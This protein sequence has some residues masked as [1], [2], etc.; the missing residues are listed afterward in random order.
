MT[1]T[2]RATL[3]ATLASLALACDRPKDLP[4][5]GLSRTTLSFEAPGGSGEPAPQTVYVRNTGRGSLAAPSATITYASGAGWLAA[6]VSGGGA[7]YTVTVQPT[8]AG[9]APGLYGATLTL[10]CV[11]AS[12]SPA[13]VD[14]IL[15]VPDPRFILS[16]D[17]LDL[18]APRGGGDP[19][20]ATF[21]VVNGGR[22]TLPVPEVA[23]SYVG[24][25]GW[26]STEVSGTPDAYTV[27]VFA[28]AS[29]FDSGAYRATLAISAP[30]AEGPPRTLL[31]TLTVPPAEIAVAETELW[32][33]ALEDGTP[34]EPISLQIT[35]P[36][37]GR[38]DVPTVAFLS[39]SEWLRPTVQGTT[40][41][42]TLRVEANHQWN[43]L[44]AGTYAGA[45]KVTAPDALNEETITVHFLVP[46]S[47]LALSANEVAWTQFPDCATPAPVTI[48]VEN[49]GA[50]R[51]LPPT[52]TIP[53]DAT[54]WL[55]AEIT[56]TEPPYRVTFAMTAI[57]PVDPLG[58]STM[59][60]ATIEA[61]DG[62][63]AHLTV[64]YTEATPVE[65]S[66]T[67]ATPTALWIHSQA[68][69]GDPGPGRISVRTDGACIPAP[70]VGVSY[71]APTDPDWIATY[72]ETRVQRHDV[73][74]SAS[75]AGMAPGEAR[76]ATL[77]LEASPFAADVP[78]TL[79]VG[80]PGPTGSMN[81]PR[82]LGHVL[83]ALPDGR[84]LVT[85]GYD[86]NSHALASAEIYDPATAQWTLIAPMMQPRARHGA[87]ALDDGTV[88]VCGGVDSWD[89]VDDS[90][91]VLR[92]TS[93]SYLT[94]LAG[95]ALEP[96]LVP[97]LDG[98]VLVLT[99]TAQLLDV[100]LGSTTTCVPDGGGGAFVSKGVRLEDGRILAT[101]DY[102]AWIYDPGL[103]LWSRTDHRPTGALSLLPD[104]RVLSAGYGLYAANVAY[105]WD[106]V[107]ATWSDTAAPPTTHRTAS[108]T[109]LANGK[110][111][112]V[113]G[114]EY[115]VGFTADLEVFDPVTEAWS[116]VGA[117]P[118]VLDGVAV[119]RLG[120]GLILIAG[121]YGSVDPFTTVAEAFTW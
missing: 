53:A 28:D 51:L 105:L 59:A 72:V 55:R 99:G 14:V 46:P 43:Q 41:P 78:V 58:R 49:A 93:W 12:S 8:T 24:P 84:A 21:Q 16:T 66:I 10:D 83:T 7:P 67:V 9:L 44:E 111:L 74:V 18:A 1:G 4:D 103:D 110:V 57:P 11:G 61:P 5:M 50:G 37:G 32:I 108:V 91:E 60:L 70:S 65:P 80:S 36:G 94:T 64:R 81:V 40:E 106:P 92:G 107:T 109:A 52:V 48:R 54:S 119:A 88:V 104:G 20:A 3:L 75:A 56:G 77:H 100:A 118:E 2:A 29:A 69:T 86:A 117:L 68:G 33:W 62:A 19:A 31:V 87:I 63:W 113:A 22:G 96:T 82:R 47:V 38:L 27:T 89:Y 114:L 35:N 115:G 95:A 26:L 42:F 121:G 6:T 112:A 97:L 39:G 79:T 101:G 45:F 13:Q 34:P 17:H 120:S 90:C 23:I 30:A 25:T 116:T 85:G 15:T 71:A 73:T 102:E 76:S 98:R